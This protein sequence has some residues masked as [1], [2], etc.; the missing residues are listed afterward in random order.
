M[1][2][3]GVHMDYGGDCKDLHWKGVV[4]SDT[5]GG[6]TNEQDLVLCGFPLNV[7]GIQNGKMRKKS[8]EL[9]VEIPESDWNGFSG[10]PAQVGVRLRLRHIILAL[11]WPLSQPPKPE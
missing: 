3:S 10:S 8:W 9:N 1:E 11:I 6:H 7:L 2:S 5:K 4:A